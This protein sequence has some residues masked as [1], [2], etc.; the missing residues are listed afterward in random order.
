MMGTRG[1]GRTRR[2]PGTVP[3]LRRLLLALVPLS[4]GVVG[5]TVREIPPQGEAP[6]GSGEEE[7]VSEI[8]G[9]LQAS[10]ASWN[11][12]D[13]DG[14]LDDYWKSDDLTF[15]G[16]SGVTRGWEGVRERYERGY[17]APGVERDSLRFE[18]LEVTAL[19]DD[20]AL[21]LG[22]YVL[23]RPDDGGSVRD[24][25]YFS[26]VLRRMEDGWKIIHDHTSAT[27]LEDSGGE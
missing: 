19:G 4:A 14:F 11:A 5:C 10:S 18:D 8:T 2:G 13:L 16:A 6:E 21:A 17:W 22:R 15:S 7:V 9:M 25:G 1:S 20:H 23:F 12:G 3:G 24:T 26:L 27:P